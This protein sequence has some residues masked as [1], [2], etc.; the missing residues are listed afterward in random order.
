MRSCKGLC[1]AAGSRTEVGRGGH[2]PALPTSP[3]AV[4][5][6]RASK[7]SE[8]PAAAV[9]VHGPLLAPKS[10]STTAPVA[11]DALAGGSRVMRTSST[12][13]VERCTWTSASTMALAR[14]TAREMLVLGVPPVL[15]EAVPDQDECSRVPEP[16]M[17]AKRRRDPKEKALTVSCTSRLQSPAMLVPAKVLRKSRGRKEP[18]KPAKHWLVTES[19]AR[20]EKWRFWKLAAAQ[21]PT[22]PVALEG[23]ATSST[24][25]P[26]WVRV[27]TSSPTYGWSTSTTTCTSDTVSAAAVLEPVST[28]VVQKDVGADAHDPVMDAESSEVESTCT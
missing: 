9:A 14:G 12:A 13:L 27:S 19:D 8:P 26:S 21:R 16:M 24:D 25:R 2:A 23:L 11:P 18:V 3:K 15:R 7:T 28:A 10:L 6:T 4:A 1:G 20:S 5:P 22:C 17:S